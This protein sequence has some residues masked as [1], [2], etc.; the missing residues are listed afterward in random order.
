MGNTWR[1]ELRLREGTYDGSVAA[2]LAILADHGF[3]TLETNGLATYFD[4]NG[5]DHTVPVRELAATIGRSPGCHAFIDAED[6][7]IVLLTSM[8]S[9][10]FGVLRD[11][12]AERDERIANKLDRLFRDAINTLAPPFACVMDECSPEAA[13]TESFERRAREYAESLA[14]RSAP[15]FLSWRT[16]FDASWFARLDEQLFWS[17][18]PDS[19]T[20]EDFARGV[21]ITLGGD[22]PWTGDAAV[23]DTTLQGYESLFGR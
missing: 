9:V 21:L 2:A 20:R 17:L 13:W 7:D 1:F 12:R 3:R 4:E 5:F 10:A 8:D 11:L 14:A 6:E 16:Y 22:R 18:G 15:T 19:C 23:L